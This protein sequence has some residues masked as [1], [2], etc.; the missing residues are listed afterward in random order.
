MNIYLVE[1]GV[2]MLRFMIFLFCY[3]ICVISVGN[4]LLYLNYRALGYSWSA[5]GSFILSTA[6]LYLAIG[7]FIVLFIVVFDLIPLRSPFF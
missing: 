2:D 7:S 4:L 1:D 5:V 6:E 3:G